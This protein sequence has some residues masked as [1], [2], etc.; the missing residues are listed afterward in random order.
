MNRGYNGNHI[1]EGNKNKSQFLD[2]LEWAAKQMKIRLFAYCVLDNHYH[3]VMENS[4]GRMSD[5]AKLLNGQYGSYYRKIDGGKGYVFQSRFK[6]T[7]IENDSYLIKSIVYCLQNPVRAGI[8]S[9]AE[10]YIWSSA[11]FYFQNPN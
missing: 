6:S 5:F 3:L 9:I 10:H 1:F 11:R 4:S 2:Y 8:V 7:I